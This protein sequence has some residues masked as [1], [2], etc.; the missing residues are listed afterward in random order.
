MMLIKLGPKWGRI[1]R[2]LKKDSKD[3]LGSEMWQFIR[4]EK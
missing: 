2:V 1:Q 3:G 4:R